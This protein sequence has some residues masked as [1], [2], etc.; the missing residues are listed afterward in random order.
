MVV[1]ESSRLARQQRFIS[2]A[3]RLRLELLVQFDGYDLAVGG[4]I[5]AFRV[6]HPGFHAIEIMARIHL[7]LGLEA[8]S[9]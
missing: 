6:H 4:F 5:G 7:G 2:L 1:Q 9:G 3:S 8:K